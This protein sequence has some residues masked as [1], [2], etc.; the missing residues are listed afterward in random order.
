[1]G[2]QAREPYEA[3]QAARQRQATEGV[4]SSGMLVSGRDREYSCAGHPP[5]WPPAS[6]L[7]RARQDSISSTWRQLRP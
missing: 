1:M 4:P 3:L 7:C 5:V 6:A 2:L